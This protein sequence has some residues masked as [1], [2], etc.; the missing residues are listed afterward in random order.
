MATDLAVG[1][2][3]AELS[4]RLDA[5]SE[6][7]PRR[8]VVE[9]AGGLTNR[10]LKMSTSTGDVVARLSTPESA[11]LAIDRD[12]EHANSVAAAASGAAPEIVAYNPDVSVLVVRYV[13]GRTWGDE[14]VLLPAN[15]PRLAAVCR[16][17]HSGPR[18]RG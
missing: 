7:V 18:F 1:E 15:A 16:Q 12:H 11:L 2:P 6:L 8:D 5:V 13:A 10:N 4:A 9:L 17:L 14:D 3:T